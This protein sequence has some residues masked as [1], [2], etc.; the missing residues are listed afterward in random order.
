M[1]R[2]LLAALPLAVALLLAPSAGPAAA[3]TNL[4]VPTPTRAAPRTTKVVI[5]TLDAVG[6]NAV[7]RLGRDDMPTL[8]R[9]IRQGASTLNA[10]TPRETTL[11][12]PNHTSIVTGRRV[13]ADRGGHGVVW[14]DTRLTPRTV[15]D[16]AGHR[17]GSVFTAVHSRRR[18][19]ALFTSKQKLSLFERSW[20]S[21]VGRF[22]VD[23]GNA[24]LTR[25]ARADI[26]E[27]GRA[28]TFLHLSLPDDAGH[29]HGF[30]SPEFDA[31]ARTVDRLLGRVVST[32]EARPHLRDHL[33]LIVT[34]DHGS[35]GGGH[36]DPTEK[37]FYRV[38]FVAWGVG[39]EK[40]ADL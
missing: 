10:R 6:S 3:V 35:A 11:T 21:S 2:P 27:H 28:L 39:V 22:V 40:G 1:R 37:A 33:T 29:E 13:D 19:P 23:E 26:V 16:A 12:L 36:Y 7:R 17:V 18:E 15:H 30:S 5:V 34:A 4:G 32:I 24:R 8:H 14:N 20:P 9:L 31:A 25:L 38:P